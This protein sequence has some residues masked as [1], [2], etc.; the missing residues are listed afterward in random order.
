MHDVEQIGWYPSAAVTAVEGSS[1]VLVPVYAPAFIAVNVQPASHLA[2][3]VS[4][5]DTAQVVIVVPAAVAE[6]PPSFLAVLV[7]VP[8]QAGV[9]MQVFSKPICAAVQTVLVPAT[10]LTSRTA[11]T[12]YFSAPVYVAALDVQPAGQFLGDVPGT[13]VASLDTHVVVLLAK[14]KIFAVAVSLQT[15][16]VYLAAVHV[17]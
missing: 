13:H 6:P 10:A 4:N 11:G 7:A 12:S 2:A 9:E 5:G 16:A 1:A 8:V 3:E 17:E 14:S 15:A